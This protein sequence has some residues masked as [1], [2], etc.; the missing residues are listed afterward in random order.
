[1][2]IDRSDD[3]VDDGV[4][5][6]PTI[7]GALVAVIAIYE[8]IAFTVNRVLDEP[9]MPNTITLIGRINP[10]ARRRRAR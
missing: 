9:V 8:V 1:M 6:S 7:L 4:H 5:D 3:S 10:L 2:N